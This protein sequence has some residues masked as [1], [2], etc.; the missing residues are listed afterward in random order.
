MVRALTRRAQFVCDWRD[1]L[2]DETKHLNTVFIKNNYSTDFIER[3]TY[4]R[5]N[6]S[7]NNSYTTTATVTIP[8][9]WGTSKTIARILR[10]YNIR[11][12]H[13]PMFTL[14]RLLTNVKDKDEPE[15]RS[16]AVHKIKCSDCQATFIGETGRNLNTRL[17][18]HKRAT[19]KG[20]LNNNIAEHHLK[21]ATLSTG[22]LLS[23]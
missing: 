15:G 13:K 4:V 20:D 23:V 8:Y 9:I 18:E 14:R 16:E 21:Q 3:N 12:A 17:N 19:K 5:P 10:P 6:D 22:T 7:S 1:S 11:V 2:T